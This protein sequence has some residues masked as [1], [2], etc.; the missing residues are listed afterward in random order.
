M[1]RPVLKRSHIERGV[2]RAIADKGLRGTTIQDIADAADVSPGLLYRYWKNRD[3]LAIEVYRRHYIALFERFVAAAAKEHDTW[4]RLAAIVRGFLAL[5]DE[6]PVLVKFLLFSLHE[7][8]AKVPVEKSARALLRRVLAEGMRAGQLRKMDVELA[9]ELVI[10]LIIQPVIGGL[11]HYL[12]TPFARLL[13]EIMGALRR[14]LGTERESARRAIQC[15][16][17]QSGPRKTGVRLRS[18]NSH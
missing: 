3:A 5:A 14:V 1:A 11:Y 8:S 10:G 6:D 17:P 15:V 7:L 13:D 9:C 4:G 18:P 2:V 12:P 16:P